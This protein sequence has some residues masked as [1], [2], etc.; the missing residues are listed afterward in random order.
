LNKYLAAKVSELNVNPR[1]I[2]QVN[3]L[4]IGL[5][6]IKGAYYAWRNICPHAGAPVCQ[7][8]ISGTTLPTHVYEYEYGLEEQ[9]LRCPWHGWEFDLTT[10]KHL[11]E[12]S[13]TKLRG[14]E[15]VVENGK[16]YVLMK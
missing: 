5:F 10:G 4:E 9:V 16:L 14:Y 11:V 7:G 1:K 13:K 3:G 8:L 12:G 6:H 2:V 15:V